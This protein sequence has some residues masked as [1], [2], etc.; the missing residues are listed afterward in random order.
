MPP[1][2]RL[3]NEARALAEGDAALAEAEAARQLT[4]CNACRYCEGY[5]AVF[6]AMTR[7]LVFPAADVHYLANLCHN[8]GDCLHACQYAPPHEFAVDI[9]GAMARVRSHTYARHAWPRVL[10][11]TFRHAGLSAGLALL[12]GLVLWAVLAIGAGGLSGGLSGGPS[13]G[14]TANFYAVVPHHLLAAV[15]GTLFIIAL[16][17][18]G[19]GVARFWRGQTPGAASGAA[20]AETARDML[21]LTYLGG[22]HGLGCNE[23]DDRFTLI[24]RRFH[25]LTFYGFVLCFA[26]TAVATLYHYLLDRHAPYPLLSL[27]VVLGTA[28][29]I[30]LLAGPFG[31]L[32]LSLRRSATQGTPATHAM[33]RALAILLLLTSATGLA[34]LAWRDSSAMPW[35]L[36]VHLGV[37]TALFFTMAYGKF[38]HGAYRGAALLKYAIERRRP[39]GIDLGL[40]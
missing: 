22:G 11:G 25:H 26:A 24:R 7:R 4:I 27:P 34:L 33:D 36:V 21:C 9:P 31:L 16:A 2:E 38:V 37:V 18:I 23:G 35:L 19:I 13:G 14:T 20:V 28:G 1:L 15:F 8:C 6:P 3:V 29:G 17:V 40:D 10:A 12:I 32:W 39:S 30:G 5:C